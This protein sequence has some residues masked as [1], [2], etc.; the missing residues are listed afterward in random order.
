MEAANRGAHDVGAKSIGL[1]ITLPE[2]QLP[3]AYV[4]PDLCF[5]FRYFAIRKMHFLLRAKGLVVFPGGFGTLDELFEV[6]TL[7][8]VNRM[9][10]IPV[11]LYCREYWD[12][13][14]DFQFLADEGTIRDEHLSL[15]QYAETPEETWGVIR[16]FY[17][18]PK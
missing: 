2:E 13:V 6:L 12:Q 9:Q 7:R 8:Q 17:R 11:L 10:P 15:I 5:Q 3:N 4:T 14:V 16:D 1:N 18:L